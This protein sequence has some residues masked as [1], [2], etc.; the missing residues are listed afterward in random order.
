MNTTLSTW[1]LIKKDVERYTGSPAFGFWKTLKMCYYEEALFYSILFR[2]C[3]RVMRIR[4]PVLRFPLKM[5]F[6]WILYRCCSVALG[7]HID[8][9][10]AIGKGLYIGHH[11]CIFIGAVEIG[12]YCNISQEVTIGQG[13]LGTAREG[14]PTIGNRVYIAP[15][16]KIF[17]QI[18]IGNNVS[19]GANTVISK[20][21]P[22]NAIVVGNPGRIVGYQ[23]SSVHIQNV[24]E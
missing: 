3:G 7:I 4:N 2:I 24:L 20:D 10:A 5:V 14:R 21:I 15:G 6:V 13:R 11:G 8:L 1:T 22:D 9:E 18:T 17:G 19:I 12:E 16:A 23:E